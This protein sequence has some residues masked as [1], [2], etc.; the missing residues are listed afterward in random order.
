MQ[1]IQDCIIAIKMTERDY[2]TLRFVMPIQALLLIAFHL[3]IIGIVKS[4]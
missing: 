4:H 1:T 2:I 3:N